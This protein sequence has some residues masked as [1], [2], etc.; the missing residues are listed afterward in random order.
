MI[1]TR[2]QFSGVRDY[3]AI[4][5]NLGEA[6]EH[7]LITG[8]NGAGKS[9]LSFAMGAVLNSSKVDIDGLKSQ[10]LQ[11]DETWNA[12][13][14]LLFKNEGPSRID[15]PF[16]IEFRLICEKLPNQPTKRR[17]EIYD[18][19]TLNELTLKQ[20]Y[21]SG[22]PNQNNLGA[23]TRAL[24]LKYKIHPDLYYLIWYQ[25]EVNQFSVMSPE[26]RFRI[27]SE[28]HRISDMQKKWE[29]SLENVKDAHIAFNEAS[30]K[31]KG[32]EHELNIARDLKERFENNRKRLEENG[33]LY[34]QTT[35]ALKE[36]KEKEAFQLKRYIEEHRIDLEE[37]TEEEAILFQTIED[38]KDTEKQYDKEQTACVKEREK[39]EG[40]LKRK[41]AELIQVTAEKEKL[42]T[43]LNELQ[44][45]YM[46]LPYTEK[47]TE[48]RH[49]AA[50]ETLTTLQQQAEE[51]QEQ[52]TRSENEI[53]ENRYEQAKLQTMIDQWKR[54]SQ[55]AEVLLR[56]YTSSYQLKKRVGELENTLRM[57]R[58][59]RDDLKERQQ[60]HEDELA[61]LKNNQIESPRQQEAIKHLKQQNIEAY[62][63]RRF[64]KMIDDVPIE[65]EGLFDTIKYTVFYDGNRCDPLN[66]LYHV[67]LKKIIPTYVVTSLPKY[68]LTMRTDLT[69]KE[70]NDAARV[71]WWI[72]QFF[73]GEAPYVEGD[74]LVDARG[75]RGPQE[76][77]MFILSKKAVASRTAQVETELTKMTE[78]IR[79]LTETIEE[80][81]ET[82]RS[83]NADVRKVEEAEALLS[84][85]VDQQYRID[86]LQQLAEQ[87]TTL[88]SLK[89][90]FE[91]E[92]KNIWK[93]QYEVED[94]LKARTAD[95]KVYEQ[96][97]QQSKQLE[98]LQQ[99]EEKHGVLKQETKQLKRNFNILQDKLDKLHHNVRDHQRYM[100]SLEDEQN[101][102][103]QAK[104]RY[105]AQIEEKEQHHITVTKIKKEYA[106]ELKALDL[107]IPEL[108]EKAVADTL[109]DK[110]LYDLQHEQGQA[111]TNF[112]LARDEKNIDPNAVD[113]YDTLEKEV[114]RKKEELQTTKNLLEDNELR[115]TENERRLEISINQQVQRINFLFEEYMGLFQFE[116]QIKYE[117]MMDK[118]NRPTFKLFIYVRKEGHQSK[119][120][121][122]SVKARGGRVGK[123]VSGGEESLSSL[124]FALALLQNIEN[125]AGFIVLDEFDSALDDARKSKVF[126]LY[127]EKLARK[128]IVLSPKAHENDYYERFNK[129]FIVSHDPVE[130]ASYVRGLMIKPS[131]ESFV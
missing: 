18:G 53:E 21:R 72:E 41:E 98:R 121:D 84:T 59:K 56:K 31:Q 51:I 11:E 30:I 86:Q 99:T 23:Y 47:E 35:N 108:V 49:E 32:Y 44:E 125:Q 80:Q 110:S 113:N 81:N 12:N 77:E 74:L 96:F 52:V 45:A 73:L 128:L 24:E 131:I 28:M 22:D 3:G 34:A 67:S 57:S 114:R 37:L 71:L 130:L 82:Y 95:L 123:G 38:A 15:A 101:R 119:F 46:K 42:Q 27:F 48:E 39:T 1:P 6:K 94:E 63:L 87:F 19:D 5:M 4:E 36:Q 111:K 75:H 78:E 64:V 92:A 112:Q 43:L 26:E 90:E 83:W 105:E 29:T 20:A 129:A 14:H 17:Y 65:Q 50:T 124:L 62:P 117:K 106:E 60:H 88:Q 109:K 122:V 97:G 127:E 40:I 85:K 58:G 66:D 16:Y 116:G 13:V 126:Q 79:R 70:K 55:E 115:A 9:T 104:A 120:E 68:G 76:R 2:L 61:L 10:N 89:E 7:V 118:H 33:Y 91:I 54:D 69:Q 103:T 25:Q 8:P 93:K 100:E 102:M 107:L